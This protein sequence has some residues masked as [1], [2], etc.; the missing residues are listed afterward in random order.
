MI[1]AALVGLA[2]VAETPLKGTVV[3]EDNTPIPGAELV[4]TRPTPGG[5]PIVAQGKTNDKGEFQLDR[6]ADLA[7]MSKYLVPTLWV[8]APG[9]RVAVMRFSDGVPA[10]DEPVRVVLRPAAPTEFLVES[11]DGAP[12]AGA[13]LS[14]Q[15]IKSEA[16]SVPDPIA[17]LAERATGPDGRALLDAFGP[18]EIGAVDI[19]AKGY[20][21]QPR[22]FD[23]AQPGPKRARLL[24]VV[25][26][27]GRL[28]PEEGGPERARGWRV[29]AWTNDLVSDPRRQRM[30]GY[31]SATTDDEGRFTFPELAPGSLNLSVIPPDESELV[32]DL[33]GVHGISEGRE[34]RIEIP[35]R[36]TTTVTGLVREHDSGKPVAGVEFTLSRL[37][38][39]GSSPRAVTDAEGRYTFHALPGESRIV[40]LTV[41]PSY[42]QAPGQ[43]WE[44]F[45]VP[46]APAR[47]EMK[48]REVL[49]AAPPLRGEVRDENGQPVA[50]ATVRA[51]WTA[52]TPLGGTAGSSVET[53]DAQGGF[54]RAGIAPGARITITARYRD[55]ATPK[56]VV[57]NVEPD[58]PVVVTITPQPTIALAGRVLGPGGKP[59]AGAVV[60]LRS[61]EARATPPN[62]FGNQVVLEGGNS[63]RTGPDGL[64]RTAKE[65]ERTGMEY[66][67]EVTAD[68]FHPEKTS[69]VPVGEVDVLT[70]PDMTLRQELTIRIVSGRVV[71]RDGQPVAGAKVFQ[72]GDGPIR[73]ETTADADGRFRLPG[74]YN[75]PALV[76]AE[77]AGFRFGGAIVAAGDAQVEIK[78][79]RDGEPPVAKQQTLPAP[80]SRAEERKLAREL[81]EPVVAQARSDA[82]GYA[83]ERVLPA[84]ARIDPERVLTMIE[85]RV[86]SQPGAALGQVVL[87]Q[88]EDD[89]REAVATIESDRAP[90]ARASLFPAL[91]DAAADSDP[92]RRGEWLDRALTEARRVEA[93]EAKLPLLR[94]LADR[95]LDVGELDRA[96]PI[97]REGQTVIEAMPHE[98]YSYAREQFG[99][100]LA[101]LDLPAARAIFE[102]KGVTQSNQPSDEQ[103]RRHLGEAAVRLAAFDPAEAERLAAIA[104]PG[105][106]LGDRDTL[107]FR[108]ARR[109]ARA[110]LPRAR[111]LLETIPEHRESPSAQPAL[112]PFGLGLM[113][114]DRAATDPDGA[115]ALLDEAF[116]G[117]LASGQSYPSPTIYMAAL[118]PAVERVE[119]DRLAERLWRIAARR[120]PRAQEPNGLSVSELATLALLTSRYDRDMADAIAAPALARLAVL[121]G[122]S[123][124][125]F[126]ARAFDVVAGYDPRAIAALIQSLPAAARK[127]ERPKVG[128]VP[129]APEVLARLA[130]AEMLGLPIAERR[131]AALKKSGFLHIMF[132]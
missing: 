8:F 14:V 116:A 87:A 120:L 26:V 77:K 117:L 73:T 22:W 32:P 89:P 132:Q 44:D 95:W 74:V 61:R 100:V 13:R 17:D 93:A 66:Q 107:Y 104:Y 99:E 59:V 7:P 80:M 57:A 36:R 78:L 67:A 40:L 123:E 118:L 19:I 37:R 49:R 102:R 65:L 48:P 45:T 43:G 79:A 75:G 71:D 122:E 115:R 47:I 53:T 63:L 114:A 86:L 62:P 51:Q 64:F 27:A 83:G 21:I 90:A 101:V 25:A 34:N 23:P 103:V 15:R 128:Q 68:G 10:A 96:K 130:A 1:F 112:V 56:P 127:T 30:A 85:N 4:L 20:G 113:A 46:E 31:A 11:P 111:K 109:M 105:P 50:G 92:A 125:S 97:L 6:P 88:Y 41:P 110:D 24:P 54:T 126:D 29:R 42:V 28:V 94:Q 39:S 106:N 131:Q 55:H 12:V 108:I 60:R 58:K 9:H 121:A 52:A 5:T 69:W 82:L 18:D 81:L 70:L 84:L 16:L 91:A 129:D 38:A 3:A 2:L 33:T 76:F 35:L 98:S 72:S 124:G 119:P